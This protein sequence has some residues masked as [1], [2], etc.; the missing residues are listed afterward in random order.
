M[1]ASVQLLRNIVLEW[2]RGMI[3]GMFEADLQI[4]EM[5]RIRHQNVD[6][7]TENSQSSNKSNNLLNQLFELYRANLAEES[8]DELEL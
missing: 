7:Y 3:V 8:H 5:L 2:Y 1:S 4:S 6:T